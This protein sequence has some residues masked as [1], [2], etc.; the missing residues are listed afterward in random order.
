MANPEH[1]KQERFLAVIFGKERTC[2]SYLVIK[3]GETERRL[4]LSEAI[5][6]VLDT[7]PLTA[8][9]K[10]SQKWRRLK[11]VIEL[12]FGLKGGEPMTLEKIGQEL[13]GIKRE[14]VRQM[15]AKAL[16]ILR[17]PSR[18]RM[19]KKFFI[20][21]PEE[22]SGKQME[23]EALRGRV[24]ELSKENGELKERL[25]QL[26]FEAKT[27]TQEELIQD[28]QALV[29]AFEVVAARH[30]ISRSVPLPTL[31][32]NSLARAG[33]SRL[34]QLKESFETGRRI[35]QVGAK[36]KKLIQEILQEAEQ[37]ASP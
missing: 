28:T 7:L 23:L 25:R 37:K 3:E 2:Y 12:R 4:A 9:K 33:I 31:V 26:G 15:E 29:K 21:T 32:W 10:D 34:S 30:P 13:G 8:G 5:E 17:H 22:Y 20:P 35:R 19:F 16:R 14:P 24:Q 1:A 36:G 18:S 11:R 27:P 6:M